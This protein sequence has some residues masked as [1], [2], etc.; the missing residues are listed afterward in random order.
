MPRYIDAERL[1]KDVE[2][3]Y[4]DG[5]SS[6]YYRATEE[7]D[8]LVGKFQMI[9][10]IYD[11]PTADVEEVRHGR[12]VQI[13]DHIGICSVC[14]RDVR[15]FGAD[16]TGCALILSAMYYRCPECGAKMDQE[17]EAEK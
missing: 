2:N 17:G 3:T 7:G 14:G 1:T 9:D 12:W 4:L 10:L 11:Q 8:T 13:D 15:T 16:K 6:N 5:D